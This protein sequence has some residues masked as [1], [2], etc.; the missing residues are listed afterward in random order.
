MITDDEIG[1]LLVQ[2]LPDGVRMTALMDS[3][4]SGTGLDLPFS[5]EPHRQGGARCPIYGLGFADAVHAQN[6]RL[7]HA[8]LFCSFQI[9]NLATSSKRGPDSCAPGILPRHAA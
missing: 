7:E 5:W 9:S 1:E 6:S 4:H 8:F 2:T 3:C